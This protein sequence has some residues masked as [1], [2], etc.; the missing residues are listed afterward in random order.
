MPPLR[1]VVKMGF[2]GRLPQRGC[3]SAFKAGKK[4]EPIQ[5]KMSKFDEISAARKILDLPERVTMDSIKSSFRRM[6]AKWHPDKCEEDKENCAEMTRKI[7][8]ADETIMDDCVH[9]Q[10]S[11]SENTVKKHQSPEEW[12]FER[13]GDDPL[14][15]NG[16]PSK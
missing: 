2:V 9:Y 13:S 4:G 3:V 1:I 12:W 16:R 14:W 11:F 7:I 5:L 6:L 15:G 10:Y 8:S